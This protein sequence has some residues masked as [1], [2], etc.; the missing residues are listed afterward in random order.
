MDLMIGRNHTR[1][2][3]RGDFTACPT[4]R[5]LKAAGFKSVEVLDDRITVDGETYELP[6]TLA[7]AIQNFD[8]G[9][10]F[11]IG[12]YRIAGLERPSKVNV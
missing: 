9:K 10:P 11:K 6:S 2:A 4:A 7:N 5:A 3:R 12:K 1:G 8:Q